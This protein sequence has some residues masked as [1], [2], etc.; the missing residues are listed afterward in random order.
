MS[1]FDFGNMV[2]HLTEQIMNEDIEDVGSPVLFADPGEFDT[3]PQMYDPPMSQR[4][5]VGPR[6]PSG[7]GLYDEWCEGKWLMEE[8]QWEELIGDDAEA[9]PICCKAT[10][11]LRRSIT[12]IRDFGPSGF[13][14]KCFTED[15]D[16]LLE[17][18]FLPEDNLIFEFKARMEEW[19]YDE[20]QEVW[21]D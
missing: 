5:N 16:T 9:L 7:I 8:H 18:H 20:E 6:A 2:Q 13:R 21:S 19:C 4:N 1:V 3:D 11:E 14:Y 12:R 10:E 17:R 15:L